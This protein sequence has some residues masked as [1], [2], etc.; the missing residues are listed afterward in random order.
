MNLQ[1]IFATCL[2]ENPASS[3]VLERIGMRKEGYELKNLRI[4]GVWH[5]SVLYAIL[6]DEWKVASGSGGPVQGQNG[7]S[8]ASIVAGVSLVVMPVLARAKRR[9][10]AGIGL[11]FRT[12]T[13]CSALWLT[14]VNTRRKLSPKRWGTCHSYK[15]TTRTNLVGNLGVEVLEDSVRY[16]VRMVTGPSE[17]CRR[18][19]WKKA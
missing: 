19:S 4:H 9:V 2:P 12:C 8:P 1:R 6:C 7:A 14:L 11:A 5:D 18:S 10:A 3:R 15:S 13:T 16:K 17:C